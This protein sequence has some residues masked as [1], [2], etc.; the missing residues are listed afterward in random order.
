[1]TQQPSGQ[2]L[3]GGPEHNAGSALKLAADKL[4]EKDF[5]VPSDCIA[6]HLQVTPRASKSACPECHDERACELGV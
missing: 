1:M 3:R 4:L 2:T 6:K 5:R